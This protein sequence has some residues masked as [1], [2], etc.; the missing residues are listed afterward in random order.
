FSTQH[1]NLLTV[2]ASQAAVAI[3][4]A[5][6]YAE[7]MNNVDRLM[8]LNKTVEAIISK[9]D[10]AELLELIISQAAKL[11]N[12]DKSIIFL[13]DTNEEKVLHVVGFG[14]NQSEIEGTTFHEISDGISGWILKERK[15]TISENLL[16]DPRNTGLAKER[17]IKTRSISRSL[18]AAPLLVQEGVIGTLTVI[19][20]EG[21][22]IFNQMDLELIAALAGQ[23]AIAIENAR[24][25]SEIQRQLQE[26]IAL[27]ES[28]MIIASTLDP[29]AVLGLIAEQMAK[30]VGSTSAYIC[31]YKPETQT[32]QVIAEYVSPFASEREKMSDFGVEYGEDS[33]DEWFH[34]MASGEHDIS[35]V[36]DPDLLENERSHMIEF[37][38]KTVLFIPLLIK[39][40]LIGYVEVWESRYKREFKPHEIT[41]CKGIA[42]QAAIALENARLYE[43]A[44]RQ[45]RERGFLY[46]A[47]TEMGSSMRLDEVSRRTI[48]ALLKVMEPDHISIL[49]IKPGSNQLAIHASYGFNLEPVLL[50]YMDDETI[51]D[52]VVRTGEPL[53]LTNYQQPL[54]ETKAV[55]SILCVPLRAGQ[56]TIGALNLE[57]YQPAAFNDENLHLITI[58]AGQLAAI[59][60]NARLVEGLEAEVA[61][62]TAEI[63]AEKEKS[64]TILRNVGDAI[65]M[66]GPDM[67]IQYVN[68]AFTELTGYSAYQILGRNII[69]LFVQEIY[70]PEWRTLPSIIAQEGSWQGELIIQRKDGRS[71]DA[72]FTVEPMF[73]AEGFLVGYVSSHK[74]I[75]RLKNL[76]RARQHFLTG[77]S[78]QLRTP[79]TTLKIYTNLLRKNRNQEKYETYLEVIDDQADRLTHLI[80]DILEITR[81]DSGQVISTWLPVNVKSL[82]EDVKAGYQ[83]QAKSAGL[84]LEIEQIAPA[85]PVVNGDLV[86]L[87]QAL[88]ELLENAINF[89]PSGSKIVMGVQVVEQEEQPW[90]TIYVRDNGAGIPVNEQK[91]IFDRFYRG[92]I[93]E[94]GHIPGTGLGLCRVKGIL[95]AHGGRVT[96]ESLAG[97][98][99]I[100]TLWL[101]PVQDAMDRSPAVLFND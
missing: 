59:V 3:D 94:S 40:E 14:F 10:L 49:L 31:R 74:D 24:L 83:E 90:I 12:A 56:R 66:F 9:L 95:E 30:S 43:D 38:A 60:E 100:F 96:M 48:D 84:A 53:L 4:N 52:W 71:Y 26:Q 75:S 62:Q 47:V 77:V 13:V 7:V 80:E 27:R 68:P 72:T 46:D 20:N 57:C 101:R 58:V 32:S 63:L 51:P 64:D 97:E 25:Y 36:D 76:N 17:L 92:R 21:K 54:Q 35:N 5:R 73:D 88:A 93:A 99:S 55:R 98:G 23:A 81:L 18:A 45:A 6:L 41:L 28:G 15:P 11:T 29:E 44:N 89:S 86:Q 61:A 22:P 79:V 85:L 33:T 91:R 19:N 65:A 67:K 1:L 37:G 16:D 8:V 34:L 69:E 70:Q 50:K 2:F 78:H 42:Q 82:L 39:N 87:G